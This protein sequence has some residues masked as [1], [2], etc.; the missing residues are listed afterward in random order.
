MDMRYSKSKCNLWLLLL[1]GSSFPAHASI[2]DYLP[3]AD[4]YP[5]CLK[6]VSSVEARTGPHTAIVPDDIEPA[7]E[8]I[9]AS[10]PGGPGAATTAILAD[11]AELSGRM[12]EAA[13]SGYLG[14]GGE[15]CMRV[16]KEIAREN[17]VPIETYIP[18]GETS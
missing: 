1:I 2:F 12:E 17:S 14:D 7:C 8:K 10:A 11:C 18:V 4:V 9:V 3:P 5:S 15:F 6:T 16:L 13:K